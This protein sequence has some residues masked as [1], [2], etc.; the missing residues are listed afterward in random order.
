M[1]ALIESAISARPD[2]DIDRAV[3]HLHLAAQSLGQVQMV[4]EAYGPQLKQLRQWH[5]VVARG[6]EPASEA[7]ECLERFI[8]AVDVFNDAIA[9]NDV[10]Y[11]IETYD[12]AVAL[13]KA[14]AAARPRY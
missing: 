14:A 8:A 4:E 13:L 2:G 11:I 12:T 1:K 7:Q 9:H 6:V 3:R 10:D 5:D